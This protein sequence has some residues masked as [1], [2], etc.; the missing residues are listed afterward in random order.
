MQSGLRTESDSSSESPATT[1]YQSLPTR[2]TDVRQLAPPA[3]PYTP[4]DLSA[5]PPSY[6]QLPEIIQHHRDLQYTEQR[7]RQLDQSSSP[8]SFNQLP[9]SN[10]YHRELQ[11][12]EQSL[13]RQLEDSGYFTYGHMLSDLFNRARSDSCNQNSER[14]TSNIAIDDLPSLQT[15]STRT[16]TGTETNTRRDLITDPSQRSCRLYFN[17]T[18][19]LRELSNSRTCA[20]INETGVSSTRHQ[21]RPQTHP[22]AYH[23]VEQT[24]VWI[25]RSDSLPTYD[26]FMATP[27]LV[28]YPSPSTNV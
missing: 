13:V 25:A 5:P 22:P 12:S 19:R 8:D 3:G 6:D 20:I 23:E 24:S 14:R 4:P 28:W 17:N 10:Q 2:H 15:P 9:A 21:P 7:V 26:E 16:R 27:S 11:N 18:E 1:D